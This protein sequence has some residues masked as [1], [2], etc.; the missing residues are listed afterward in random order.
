MDTDLQ[1]IAEQTRLTRKVNAFVGVCISVYLC[2]SV[3]SSFQR[4]FWGYRH[5]GEERDSCK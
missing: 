4:L 3:A 1:P 5:S 2:L